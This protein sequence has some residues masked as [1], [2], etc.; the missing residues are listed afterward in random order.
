MARNPVAEVSGAVSGCPSR[1]R[2][3]TSADVPHPGRDFLS[4]LVFSTC[5]RGTRRKLSA[6]T[7][8]LGGSSVSWAATA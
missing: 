4:Q 7:Q 6:A 8:A 1:M 3:R 2:D 5:A